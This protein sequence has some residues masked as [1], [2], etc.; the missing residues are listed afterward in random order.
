MKDPLVAWV[1]DRAYVFA[2]K[3]NTTGGVGATFQGPFRRPCPTLSDMPTNRQADA[4]PN[5]FSI[6]PMGFKLIVP[7]FWY[8]VVIL[9][10]CLVKTRPT[11]QE[12]YLS[13]VHRFPVHFRSPVLLSCPISTSTFSMHGLSLLQYC[14]ELIL[15]LHLV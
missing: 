5:L 3:G 10:L 4:W 1:S 12:K 6:R 11:S 7:H 8:A 9:P 15:F 2:Y 13:F 14:A